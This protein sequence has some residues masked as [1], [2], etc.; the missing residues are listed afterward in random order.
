M[1]SRYSNL[2]TA[3]DVD[4]AASPVTGRH[5]L[6]QPGRCPPLVIE[7]SAGANQLLDVFGVSNELVTPSGERDVFITTCAIRLTARE[8]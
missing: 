1:A 7:Q 2:V 6:Q 3:M 8:V 4:G 5:E